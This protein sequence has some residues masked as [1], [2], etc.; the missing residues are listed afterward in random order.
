MPL[1]RRTRAPSSAGRVRDPR[2]LLLGILVL[3]AVARLYGMARES[4][5]LDEATSLMLAR[6]DVPTLVEWTALDIHPPLYY[7]LLHIWLA[8]LEALGMAWPSEVAIR[9]LSALAGVLTV[10]VVYGLGK[11]LFGRRTGLLA[12]L[13]MAVA[14]MHIWYSQEARMYTWVT[15]FMA[16]SLLAAVRLWIQSGSETR[17]PSRAAVRPEGGSETRAPWWGVW[18][19]V[20]VLSSA[21]ALYTHYY[22]VFVLLI[23]NLFLLAL[24]VLRRRR[25]AVLWRWLAAQG[26]ILLLFAPW[27]PIFI[28]PITVGGGGWITMG[29]VGRPSVAALAQT[30]VLY[31]VGLGRETIPALV[32]RLAYLLFAALFVFGVW[33]W[34]GA[35]REDRL[36]DESVGDGLDLR[37]Y[38]AL[39]LVLGYLVLPLALAW[40][41][42]QVFKPMY[43]ARY[44]LPFLVP[45]VLLVARGLA[46]L[47]ETWW[48]TATVGLVL[49]SLVAIQAQV[50]S[51]QKPD[52]RG[53]A[54]QL[55]ARDAADNIEDGV[56]L[57]MPGWHV[58]PFEYYSRDA[59]NLYGDVPI[60]VPSFGDEA[61]AAVDEAISGRQRVWFVWETDHYTD[62]D[63]AVFGHLFRHCRLMETTPLDLVGQ[64]MLFADCDVRPAVAATP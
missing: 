54:Q 58:K 60:P 46:R 25:P 48:Q 9:S 41:A 52:W 55:I 3:A 39:G 29:G 15:L 38:E 42:S 62:P 8:A 51:A 22:A 12:A 19:G 6:M 30:A 49:V 50:A 27:L 28:L 23:Q 20:Y 7:T 16:A 5:W 57:F 40:G 36:V 64:V 11:T 63:G 13:L 4:L 17:A 47:P 34:G 33:S 31:M 35:K 43:S 45:F 44:M 1:P 26:A 53:L 2:P 21:A 18:W 32:R 59:L 14:P 24:W 61:L 37:P 56:V 10:G